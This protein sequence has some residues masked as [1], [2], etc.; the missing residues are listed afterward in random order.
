MIRH[1]IRVYERLL[2]VY[3]NYKHRYLWIE[4]GI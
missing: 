3:N 4:V 1:D 2:V